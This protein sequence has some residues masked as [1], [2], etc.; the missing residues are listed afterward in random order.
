LLEDSVEESLL[1]KIELFKKQRG[2]FLPSKNMPVEVKWQKVEDEWR[3]ANKS[4]RRNRYE[5]FL[6]IFFS[7]LK[8]KR[9]SFGYMFLEK[10]E[11]DGIEKGFL[12]NQP[13]NKQ[14]FFS[15]S[16]FNSCITVL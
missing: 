9:M 6:D 12:Q 7:E 10:K 13:D 11:Y 5:D 4:G 2:L 1:Q 15:C 8:T 3:E 14:N 16:I